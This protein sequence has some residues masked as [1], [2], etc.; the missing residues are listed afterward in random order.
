MAESYR[1][2]MIL[3]NNGFPDDVRVMLEATALAEAGFQVTVICPTDGCWKPVDAFRGVRILRYPSPGELPGAWGHALEFG[4]SLIAAGVY[5]LYVLARHGFD[6]IHIHSPPDTNA[7][8]GILYRGLGKTFIY[9][10]HDLSPELYAAQRGGRGSAWVMR[11]LGWFE[12]LACRA[13]DRLIATNATQREVQIR[14]GGAAACRCFI[15]RNG[16]N[17]RFLTQ[18]REAAQRCEADRVIIGYVGL[19][20]PQDGV[21]QLIHALGE[22]R[23]TLDFHTFRACIVGDGPALPTLRALSHRLGL[24]D[25]IEFTGRVPFEEVPDRIAGFDICVTPDPANDYNNSCTTIKTMEYMALRKPVV[26]FD[27]TENTAT[28]GDAA[29]VAVEPTPVGLARQILRLVH[30]KELR[31]RLGE[32]G[33]QRIEAGLRWSDQ[34]QVLVELYAELAHRSRPAPPTSTIAPAPTARRLGPQPDGAVASSHP[35]IP[36]TPAFEGILGQCL[37]EHIARDMRNARLGV[38]F[39]VYYRLRPLIPLAVRQRLQRRQYRHH[40]YQEW[41]IPSAWAAEFAACVRQHLASDAHARAIAPWPDDARTAI[42][43]THDVESREGF[44]RMLDIAAL[45]EKYGFRS[46]WNVVPH[47]YRIDSGV[48]AELRARGHEIGVHGWSHDG[49][50]FGSRRTFLKRAAMINSVM[51][52]WQ[53]EG[54]RAPMVHRNLDWMQELGMNYDSSCFDIDPYQAMPGGVGAPWPFLFGGFVEL[55]YTLPQ[56]HTLD[57]LGLDWLATWQRKL[58]YLERVGGM[59]LSITHP[60]YI[61]S[62]AKR[63]AYQ[64][65]L[66]RLADHPG[67]WRALPR[68]VA[69]WWRDRAQSRV[70]DAPAADRPVGP[71]GLRGRVVPLAEL[72]AEFLEAWE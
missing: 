69:A 29:L 61:D 20:S 2:L 48:L 65:W 10:M 9:D 60:D 44:A 70:P 18:H 34:A 7:L 26:M 59:A 35:S 17:D 67:G 31:K 51:A 28:A 50:L 33:R 45:E 21:D 16:P 40:A 52:Q 19:I 55:P 14:R 53:S 66:A 39:H 41:T 62:M 36:C 46:A 8:L 3:E 54:F 11:A 37:A 23:Q 4:Y 68:D 12:R 32:R 47:N 72:F 30:D 6:A 13:A 43:L 15:V 56:D 25:H 64:R 38:K 58:D 5:S 22:L 1:V 57:R 71:A 49:R 27:T 24:D 42:V 63:D